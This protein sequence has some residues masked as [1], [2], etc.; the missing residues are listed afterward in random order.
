MRQRYINT[1]EYG[2]APVVGQPV[3]AQEASAGQMVTQTGTS[4]R[5][6][7]RPAW[8]PAQ[9]VALVAGLV[10]TVIGAIALARTGT[11]FSNVSATHAQA[12]GLSFSA[13]SAVVQLVAGVLLLGSAVFPES[14][15]VGLALFGVVLL[16]WGIVIAADTV[17]LFSTWGY[18][19]STGVLYIVIGAVLLVA[20]AVSP[21]FFSRQRQVISGQGQQVGRGYSRV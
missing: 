19:R 10:L 14:A 21:I 18:S 9:L 1:P 5:M 8:S 4:A 20:A 15:K 12:A 2:E 6:T 16:A 17:R 13:V 11:N 7:E 3:V